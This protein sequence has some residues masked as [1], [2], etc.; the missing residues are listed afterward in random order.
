MGDFD[1]PFT[2]N[3]VTFARPVKGTIDSYSDAIIRLP[4][5]FYCNTQ[6]ISLSGHL[7]KK[8]RFPGSV[9]PVFDINSPPRKVVRRPLHDSFRPPLGPPVHYLKSIGYSKEVG[10]PVGVQEVY[11]PCKYQTVLLDH[12]KAELVKDTRPKPDPPASVKS[13]VIN[14]G[15]DVK[16]AVPS[17]L[18][19]QDSIIMQTAK[20][21]RSKNV[22][23]TLS[24]RGQNGADGRLGT[25]GA[26]GS[27]GAAGRSGSATQRTQHGADGGNG[28]LGGNGGRGADGRGAGS[29][30][31]SLS[32]SPDELYVKTAKTYKINLGGNRSETV[33]LVDCKGGSGGKGGVGGKGGGG[34][35]GG[36]GG[37][38]VKGADGRKPGEDGDNG[39]NAGDGGDGGD[40]GRGGISGDGGDAGDGGNCVIRADDARLLM[41]VEADCTPGVPGAGANGGLGGDGGKPGSGG[42]G[43]QGGKNGP[44]YQR[45]TYSGDTTTIHTTYAS[46]GKPGL[47]GRKGR[48]GKRGGNGTDGRKG[49][50]GRS[51][52]ILWVVGSKGDVKQSATR[53]DAKVVNF[54]VVPAINGGIFE[55][56][57]SITVSGVLVQNTGGLD[58]PYGIRV[59]IPS[60]ETIKFDP[61]SFDFNTDGLVKA[62]K[63]YTIPFEFQGRIADLAPPNTPGRQSSSAEFSTRIELL[64]RPFEQSIVKRE[65]DVQYPVHLGNLHCPKIM[66]RG[67]IGLITIEVNNISKLPYGS[68]NG[69]G[70]KV[71]L[72]LHFDARIIPLGTRAA[73]AKAPYVVTYDPSIR[74]GMYIE[75]SEIPAQQGITVSITFQ[76]ENRAELFDY[77]YWQADLYLRE[78]LIEY[79]HQ[80]FRVSP[81]YNHQKP[82]ADVLLVTGETFTRKE[83]EVWQHIFK[84]LNVSVDYWDTSR[85]FGFSVDSR[86][87]T[88]HRNTWQGRYLGK[89]IIY[90][91]SDLQLLMGID[92]AQH[93]HGR[94]FREGPM[95]ELGSSLVTFMPRSTARQQSEKVMLKHLAVVN[96]SVEI[97]KNGYGGKHM[98][99]PKAHHVPRPYAKWEKDFVKKLEEKNPS[100][101]PLVLS[102]FVNIQSVGVL[103]YSYGAIDIRQVPILKSAK[104]LE[105]DGMGFEAD[106]VPSSSDVHLAT[107]YGQA[108]LATIYSLPVSVKLELMKKKTPLQSVRFCRSNK[109]Q[110]SLEEV[111]MIS[112]AWEV[113]DELLGCSGKAQR[114]KEL[115]GEIEKDPKAYIESS[116]VILRGLK[117]IDEELRKRKSKLKGLKVVQASIAQACA[118]IADTSKQVQKLLVN[119]GAKPCS[120]E[121][122]L[123]LDQLVDHSR[124]HRCHQYSVEEG[125]WKLADSIGKLYMAKKNSVL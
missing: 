120:Q 80:H 113:A 26:G 103:R 119:A 58:L 107:K 81:T 54:D 91:Y 20:R 109:Q 45:Y 23:W 117:L 44:P 118:E 86:T 82:P 4:I 105:I 38:G 41:L 111:V 35:G 33:L 68:C 9:L 110:I 70:G 1:S 73:T 116:Q 114:M 43:G 79:N 65:L 87:G 39:G 47:N 12:N 71:G 30:V 11:N 96:A 56:N 53:Y 57:E 93:F 97:P 104:F 61:A 72:H 18:C 40:G 84:V 16:Q 6:G 112:L 37:N 55:P 88:R 3:E 106:V 94:D 95:K 31:L 64:G 21:A 14:L 24:L 19:T 52:G 49:R 5:A 99:E 75:V 7:A 90:P 78:K 102:R 67:E 60:T 74:D 122:L 46:P 8:K 125:M 2:T 29:V 77:C 34:G 27:G 98:K 100:Q 83:C 22:G 115:H 76:L 51:G 36:G 42:T 13:G 32:G 17:N 124:V 101:S 123:S 92:V 69:S 63:S 89:M 85:Y 25:N 62:G 28:A 15:S 50:W 108:F 59:L 121:K 48:H 10:L 66:D